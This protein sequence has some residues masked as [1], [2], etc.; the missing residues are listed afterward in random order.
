VTDP[1]VAV[2]ATV[3]PAAGTV[4]DAGTFTAVLFE[5]RAT[6]APPVGAAFE[7]V[8][9]QEDVPPDTTDVGAHCSA[10]IVGS[11]AG[12]VTVTAAEALLLFSEAVIVA[13]WFA[14]TV[15][16]VDVKVPLV[17]PAATVIAAGTVIAV[18]FEDNAT[19]EPPVGAAFDSVNVH[20]E[21]APDAIDVGEHWSVVIIIGAVTVT[22][23]VAVL[24][25]SEAV[26]VA[27]W[28]AVTDPA[29]AVKLPVVAAAATVTDAGT[30]IAVLFEE[31]A[32]TAPPVGACWERVT[33]Q[34]D[35]PPD[36]TDAGAHCRPVSVTGGGGGATPMPALMSAWI[37]ATVRGRL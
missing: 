15:P 17:E 20:E 12:G 1:A 7:S 22:A 24:L 5:E 10:V 13:D 26:T 19:E 30:F 34:A 18:L 36:T 23:A 32:T 35:V 29:V 9:V 25:F 11:V 3:V 4:T 31:S 2:K 21:V 6:K 8:T 16:A 14:V 37:S 33:V 28:L 27:D